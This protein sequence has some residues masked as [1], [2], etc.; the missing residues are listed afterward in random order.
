MNS[1]STLSNQ[2]GR[3]YPQLG[4]IQSIAARPFRS[5]GTTAAGVVVVLFRRTLSMI[6]GRVGSRQEQSP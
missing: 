4:S 3:R 2:A 6:G 5:V 1:V